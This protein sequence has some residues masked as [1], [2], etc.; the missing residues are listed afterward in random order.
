M[1]NEP[2][3]DDPGPLPI[4]EILKDEALFEPVSPE[5]AELAKETNLKNLLRELEGEWQEARESGD[6]EAVA[7]AAARMIDAQADL[8]AARQHRK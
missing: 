1:D 8:Y 7:K 2:I 3:H 4:S 5:R 6:K